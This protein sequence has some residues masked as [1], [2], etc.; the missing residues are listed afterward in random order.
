MKGYGMHRTEVKEP[1]HQWSGIYHQG[2]GSS[3]QV[4]GPH[5]SFLYPM[6]PYMCLR[7]I[8]RK[9]LVFMPRAR[10]LMDM[11]KRFEMRDLVAGHTWFISSSRPVARNNIPVAH[12]PRWNQKVMVPS[13]KRMS[14]EN[15]HKRRITHGYGGT[16]RVGDPVDHNEASSRFARRS[17]FRHFYKYT[18]TV[19][20]N[21]GK[22]LCKEGSGI[23]AKVQNSNN[24]TLDIHLFSGPGTKSQRLRATPESPSILEKFLDDDMSRSI[25]ED[26]LGDSESLFKLESYVRDFESFSRIGN[27]PEESASH[28]LK[29]I[30]SLGNQKRIPVALNLSGTTRYLAVTGTPPSVTLETSTVTDDPDKRFLFLQGLEKDMSS[31]ESVLYKGYFL[32]TQA[33]QGSSK[34]ELLTDPQRQQAISEFKI[35]K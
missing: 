30:L 28:P 5:L 31:F 19:I 35:W 34:V 14:F 10:I 26:I 17:E 7:M 4:S 32:C 12:S 22:Q 27:P 3:T 24:D 2:G 33:G 13:E 6:P 1:L 21:A 20:D 9:E 15:A 25:L 18:A 23:I 8:V 16:E 11:L 29:E